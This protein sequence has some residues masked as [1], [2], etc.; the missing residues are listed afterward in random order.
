MSKLHDEMG[1]RVR[2]TDARDSTTSPH[3]RPH[4]NTRDSLSC[5]PFVFTRSVGVS[6]LTKVFEK[7]RAN[8]YITHIFE[9]CESIKNFY[10]PFYIGISAQPI[11]DVGE[12]GERS[13]EAGEKIWRHLA[14]F[15]ITIHTNLKMKGDED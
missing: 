5:P 14:S 9:G 15:P 4:R 1:G 6:F 11:S 12:H 8:G 2:A 7:S 13:S 3:R 10:G